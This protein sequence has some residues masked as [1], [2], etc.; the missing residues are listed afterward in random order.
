MISGLTVLITILLCLGFG[1]Y[2]GL[3][4]VRGVLALMR[5][6]PTEAIIAANE[7]PALHPSGD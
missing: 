3:L 1:L 6:R 2:L 5:Y 7:M 4:S